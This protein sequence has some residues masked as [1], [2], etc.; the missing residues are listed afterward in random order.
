MS[1][2]VPGHDV[3]TGEEPGGGSNPSDDGKGTVGLADRTAG[4]SPAA[5][6]IKVEPI[7]PTSGHPSPDAAPGAVSGLDLD[8]MNVGATDPQAP[9]HPAGGDR[10]DHGPSYAELPAAD[11]VAQRARGPQDKPDEPIRNR[12]AA[13]TSGPSASVGDAHGVPVAAQDAAEG[14]S[15]TAHS[16][17][18]VRT[19]QE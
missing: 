6:Q 12:S 14:T 1:A 16:V 4:G 10:P 7:P 19:L 13:R 3:P 18:G 5:N 17:Q 9:S 11:E 8:A 2:S 15:E